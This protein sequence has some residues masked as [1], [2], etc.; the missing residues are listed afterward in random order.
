MSKK[1]LFSMISCILLISLV[2]C[3]SELNPDKKVDGMDTDV[4]IATTFLAKPNEE[5]VETKVMA[6]SKVEEKVTENSLETTTVV[7]TVLQPEINVQV[8][9]VTSEEKVQTQNN[10]KATEPKV[11]TTTFKYNLSDA[12]LLNK[13]KESYENAKNKYFDILLKTSYNLNYDKLIMDE[14]GVEYYQ[15]ENEEIKSLKDVKNDFYKV[16][17]ESYFVDFS[18]RYIEKDSQ[19]WAADIGRGLNR[20]YKYTEISGIKSKSESEVVFKALSYYE[21]DEDG[22]SSYSKEDEFKLVYKNNQW[23]VSGFV[24]P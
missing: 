18:G 10:V 19:L 17:D 21:S 5:T 7:T 15:V 13:A 20:F 9:T 4:M 6:I 2:A 12:E 8:N 3:K 22:V 11:V 24:Y 14:N 16:F 23:L 1:I